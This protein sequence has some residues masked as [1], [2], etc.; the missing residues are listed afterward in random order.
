MQDLEHLIQILKF[1]EKKLTKVVPGGMVG[2]TFGK[3][4]LLCIEMY[5]NNSHCLQELVHCSVFL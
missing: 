5:K 3:Y 4:R 2:A 1:C